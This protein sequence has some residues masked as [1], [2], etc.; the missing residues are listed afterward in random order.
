VRR[1]YIYPGLLFSTAGLR[2][3]LSC[4]I[5]TVLR[6]AEAAIITAISVCWTIVEKISELVDLREKA[7]D[8]ERAFKV[9]K[10]MLSQRDPF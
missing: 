1:T 5:A 3:A 9:K 10:L 8:D 4:H 2:N 7:R 6:M